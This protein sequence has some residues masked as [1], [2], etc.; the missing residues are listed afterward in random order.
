MNPNEDPNDRLIDSLLR[1]QA[2]NR[3]DEELLR[4]IEA[5]MPATAPARRGGKEINFLWPTVAAAL[6]LLG[7][8]VVHWKA[9]EKLVDRNHDVA[10]ADSRLDP[11]IPEEGDAS[12]VRD[13]VEERV[14]PL[15]S[16]RFAGAA[17]TIWYVQFGLESG[18]MWAPRFTGMTADRKRLQNRV[19]AVEMLQPGDVFF[20]DGA[21][22][23]RF[24]FLRIEEREV[25][26]QRTGLVQRV[27]F[28]IYEDQRPG[29]AGTLYESQAGLPEA[30][31]ES[32]AYHDRTA[33]L[34][35]R[36]QEFEVEEG[37][38]FTV[39]G[40]PEGTEYL[41]KAVTKDR[42][43]VEHT[44]PDGETVTREIAR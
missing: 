20:K 7:I 3:P 36:D 28:A 30:E 37:M 27:K 31:L 29:K 13:V 26:S 12:L 38:K 33:T 19:S 42:I 6:V 22:A 14:D 9:D 41:L 5:R 15:D 24:K 23:G 11:V 2:K 1:E 35:N 32:R 34:R 18:G 10:S 43:V 17:T 44:G 16:L 39:P 21:M 8:G 25:K 4:A 40:D